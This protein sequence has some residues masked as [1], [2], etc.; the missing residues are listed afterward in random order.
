MID[1]K[2]QNEFVLTLREKI[3][4]NK[5]KKMCKETVKN[6]ISKNFQIVETQEQLHSDAIEQKNS[7][8]YGAFNLSKLGRMYCPS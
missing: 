8:S 3:P 5:K 4:P 2:G 1:R 6:N 7:D